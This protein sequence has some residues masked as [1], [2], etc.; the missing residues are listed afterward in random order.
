MTPD[1]ELAAAGIAL[2]TVIGGC[3]FVIAVYTALRA[4]SNQSAANFL[5]LSEALRDNVAR[6][7]AAQLDNDRFAEM[8]NLINLLETSSAAYLDHA[9]HGRSKELLRK[10]LCDILVFILERDELRRFMASLMT[11]PAT[12]RNIGHFIEL[13]RRQGLARELWKFIRPDGSFDAAI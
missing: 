7:G 13:M 2:S 5:T 6:Y 3:A 10:L 11:T 1:Q 9:I 12:F 8:S 4:N